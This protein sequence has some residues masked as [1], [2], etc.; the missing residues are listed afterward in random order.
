MYTSNLSTMGK[1]AVAMMILFSLMVIPN[2]IGQNPTPTAAIILDCD[3]DNVTISYFYDGNYDYSPNI[4]DLNCNLENPT[5]YQEKVEINVTTGTEQIIAGYPTELL[6]NGQSSVDFSISFLIYESLLDEQNDDFPNVSVNALVTEIGGVPPLNTAESDV[7]NIS[8]IV[9]Q[10]F[11]SN[12]LHAWSNGNDNFWS[13]FNDDD[14]DSTNQYSEENENG[15]IDIQQKYQMNQ[16]LEKNLTVQ[17]GSQIFGNFNILYNGDSDSTDNA[18]PCQPGQ[19]PTDCDWLNITIYNDDKILH[20][21]TEGPWPADQWNN[22]QFSFWADEENML[23]SS[24]GGLNL[25]LELT[26]KIKGD[27][28][29]GGFF[30]FPSGTPGEFR[31]MNGG[32]IEF[33]FNGF[34]NLDSDGDGVDDDIDEFPDDSNETQDSDGDGVG[35]NSD[36]FPDDANETQDSDGD[37]VGDNADLFPNDA[38]ETDDDDG[39]GVGNNTDAFPQDGNETHDDDGDGV[40]NNTDAFPQDANETM[41]TDG[42]G[43][44]DNTDPE[45]EDPSISSPT[46]I[47]VNVSDTSAYLISGAIVFLAIV[48]IFVRRKPP[49]NTDENYTQF[50]YQDSLFNED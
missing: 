23:I 7:S 43:V 39:D 5:G 47:E 44:G 16:S 34:A 27:Y 22:I 24:D 46:D 49:S 8:L 1:F 42:D 50:A 19:T 17:V 10:F 11:E 37:G 14:G 32:Y 9:E 21:H 41:D 40:G 25:S 30:G 2:S 4:S 15:V 29:D 12:S 6:V 38:N 26:M 36:E 31:I 35:D 3:E 18:G 13:N 33:P 48:I 28:Q 45:P 20:R